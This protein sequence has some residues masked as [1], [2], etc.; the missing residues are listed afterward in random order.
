MIALVEIQKNNPELTQKDILKKLQVEY[1]IK[2]LCQTS[3]CRYIKK[4]YDMKRKVDVILQ[5]E[6]DG[7]VVLWQASRTDW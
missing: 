1:G 6:R 7:L 5:A 2:D 3:V 4:I